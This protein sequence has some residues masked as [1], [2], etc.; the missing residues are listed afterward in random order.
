MNYFLQ[1]KKYFCIKI[2]YWILTG[3]FFFHIPIFAQYNK[4]FVDSMETI[5]RNPTLSD[6][7][8]YDVYE[9]LSNE[10]VN[11]N[12]RKS[13][14]YVWMG[15]RLAEKRNNLFQVATFYYDA[16]IS[17]YFANQLDSALYYYEKSSEILKQ[18]GKNETKNKK[19]VAVLQIQLFKSMGVIND[20][21]GKYDLALTN[22]FNALALA[23]ENKKQDEALELYL[24]AAST[25]TKMSN[26]QQA[27]AYYLKGEELSRQINDSINLAIA[28]QGLCRISIDKKDYT[29][30]LKYGEASD[31]I[32]SALPDIPV[33]TRMFAKQELTDV[34]LKIA[35]YDKALEYALKTV[36]LARQTGVPEY[37]ASALYMLSACYL[38]QEKFKESEET[39]FEALAA[40][41]T[42]IYIN[43]VLY[44]NIAEANIK[45]GKPDKG[46][47]YYG[48]TLNAIRAY[49]NKNF[50]SSLSEMEVKY[51]TEKKELKITALEKEKQ[52]MRGLSITGGAILLLA[53][54]A[55]LLLWRWTVQKR[56]AVEKQ[57]QLAEQQ[58]KQLEQ[59]KQLV[60]TQAVL[61]GET[62]ERVRLARDLHDGLGSMLTGAKLNL[63]EMKK[64]VTLGFADVERFN[65]AVE[66]LDDSIREMRRVAHHLMP[67]SLSRFGLK[68]AVSDFCSK[69]PSVSFAYYGNETRLDPKLE[70]II[71]R[72]INELVNNALKHAGA[73]KIMVQ[74][75]QESDRIAFAVQDDGCGFDP[76][77]VTQG[78]GLQNIRTRVVS[79]NGIIDIDSKLGEGTEINVE[80]KVES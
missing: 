62:Q 22:Y 47:A 38:K 46:I 15:V 44:Q 11:T 1:T 27:E 21:Y 59:E 50:Q 54:T 55:S 5:L 18:A 70:V 10:Y 73:D 76:S 6:N 69:L 58:V 65:K 43:S 74:I 20:T 71:Y 3:I 12:T 52:L 26:S 32:L 57:K 9:K 53:L 36:E 2:Q 13:L 39:A 29:Q 72:S 31:R 30:A 45:Q 19:N 75:I 67:D 24:D 48:K 51:E 41:T 4:E 64:D 25:Y 7:E 61:D 42:D 68:P 66:I 34:W 40:D 35:N 49:S 17:Y 33:Y 80:L 60:A 14:E 37:L 23:E 56:R 77:S 28:F 8:L 63:L 16:G 79:Y 78:M